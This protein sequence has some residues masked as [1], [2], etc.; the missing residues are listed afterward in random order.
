MGGGQIV[1]VF[2]FSWGESRDS[3]GIILGQSREDFVYVFAFLLVFPCPILHLF[4]GNTSEF[5]RKT[6]LVNL[7]VLGALL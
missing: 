7:F 5:R 4:Q 3:P 6:G 2:P 1:Y